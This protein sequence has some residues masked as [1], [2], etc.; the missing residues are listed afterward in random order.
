[1]LIMPSYGPTSIA[2]I[3]IDPGSHNLGTGILNVDIRT[4]RIVS[5]SARTYAGARLG[6][7]S[8]HTE[9]HGDRAGRIYGHR[10]NLVNLFNIAHPYLVASESP[11][12]NHQRPQVYGVL[13]EVVEACRSALHEYDPTKCLYMI[14]PP[15]V[16]NAVG[17]AGNASKDIMRERVMGISELN[18]EGAI[19]I[20]NLDEHSIDGLA[21]AYCLLSRIRAL[22]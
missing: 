11:F 7:N 13:T 21:V 8:F 1:M 22:L 16:K 3:G 10:G 19:P 12:S 14:D 5:S 17:A 2:L 6:K 15:S 4:L 20:G 18:Y 9:L